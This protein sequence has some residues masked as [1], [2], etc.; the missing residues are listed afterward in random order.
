MIESKIKF[1]NQAIDP[2]QMKSLLQSSA[3]DMNTPGFDFVSGAGYMQAQSA[4]ATFAAPTPVITDLIL[5]GSAITPGEIAFTLTVQGNY[6]NDQ[7]KVL[8]RGTE[9][10]TTVLSSTQITAEIPV[11]TGNPSIQAY[12]QPISVNGNDGGLSA[13][14]YFFSPVKKEIIITADDKSK[15][16]GEILPIF[17]ATVLVDSVPLETSGL[18]LQDIGLESIVYTSPATDFS[19]VG[20]YFIRPVR[21]FDENNPADVA[22]RELYTYTFTDGLL[23]VNK[24]PLKITPKGKTVT[25][26]NNV[27]GITFKY[28]YP[29]ENIAL[30]NKTLF[31]NNLKA[32]HTSNLVDTAIAFVNGKAIVAGRSLTAADLQN[33]SF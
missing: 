10:P 32:E 1:S 25:Y 14:L 11:F 17:T 18:T 4:I 3:L 6:F 24:L 8:F 27:R 7:T 5:P 16:F 23:A 12:T 19:N 22:L 28:E 33:M 30:A 29:D 21:T 13:P 9:L 26:G 31:N 20:I 2:A 15:R